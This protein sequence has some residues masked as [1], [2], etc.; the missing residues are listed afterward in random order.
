MMMCLDL[1]KQSACMLGAALLFCGSVPSSAQQQPRETNVLQVE[2][3]RET[4]SEYVP[5]EPITFHILMTREGESELTAMGLYETVPEGWTFAGAEGIT[6]PPP[7]V[8]PP[9]GQSGVLEFVWISPP[10][11]PYQFAYTLQVPETDR[12]PRMISGQ[13]EYRETGP[14]QVSAPAISEISGPPDEYPAIELMGDN[15][16]FLLKGTDYA[17]PGYTATDPQ[18]GDITASVVVEGAVNPDQV[19]QYILTYSV[20]DKE[21]NEASAIQRVVEV[22]LEE[23]EETA[24]DAGASSDPE[25][26]RRRTAASASRTTPAQ[27]KRA[28]R[29]APLP[30]SGG[31]AQKSTPG[32]PPGNAARDYNAAKALAQRS[33]PPAGQQIATAEK[34]GGEMSVP[35]RF[36]RDGSTTLALNAVP[37]TTAGGVDPNGAL[38][39]AELPAQSFLAAFQSNALPIVLAG[40]VSALML[41][42]AA[43]LW[44]QAY[45]TPTWRKPKSPSK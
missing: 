27:S 30:A 4:P 12:G 15:P 23:G 41:L 16:M 34:D 24:G 29:P 44:R 43:L 40:M 45:L 13:V 25:A 37:S 6:G 3:S 31:G 39:V 10:Q 42:I 17:E 21:G 18:D 20:A 22:G 35:S 36:T 9:L 28:G 33:V 26:S 19:G 5:G 7:A 38:A 32:A 14:R 2:L 8:L 1:M 11:L